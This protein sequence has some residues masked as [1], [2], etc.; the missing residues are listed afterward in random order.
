[1]AKF[2]LFLWLVTQSLQQARDLCIFKHLVPIFHTEKTEALGGNHMGGSW[3]G[4]PE[5]LYAVPGSSL[6]RGSRRLFSSGQW[7]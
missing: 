1:M 5:S 4:D 6:L 2:C 7:F 3:Q